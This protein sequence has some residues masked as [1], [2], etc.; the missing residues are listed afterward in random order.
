MRY[1]IYAY[2]LLVPFFSYGQFKN[3]L[4]AETQG[5]YEYNYFK[6]PDVVRQ[7]DV[8]IDKDSLV[9]SS[10]YQDIQLRYNA[11][12]K[13]NKSNFQLS[14]SPFSRIFYE[15]LDDSYWSFNVL[16]KYKYQLHQK[17]QLGAQLSFKRM[18][19]QGLNGAQDVLIS[20]L[21]YTKY[22]GSVGFYFAPIASNKTFLRG[23]Y[24]FKDFDSFGIRDLEYNEKGIELN[25]R[26][27]FKIKK[28]KHYVGASIIL[29]QRLYETFNA[30]SV[31]QN[32]ERDWSYIKANGY[33][34]FPITKSL[35][36]QPGYLYYKRTDELI[37]RSGFTQSGPVLEVR[38]K[39]K[40]F[41]FQSSIKH[42]IRDYKTLEA[43]NTEGPIDEKI[44][45]KY[46][47][48]AFDGAYKVNKKLSITTTVYSRIRTTNYTDIDGRSFRGYRNQFAGAGLR[49]KL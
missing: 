35:K 8:I 31:V 17:I 26:Q 43:R 49:Y 10:I 18:N 29:K 42:L 45:Y 21:G 34:S 27:R 9:S 24:N 13:K 15:N 3:N 39:S 11:S 38:F 33:Y 22:G 40:K 20:P 44:E 14:A 47:D 37:D 36:V 28:L 16:T 41:D 1:L 6:S 4:K 12:Y 19:R 5:G 2:L 23:F 30:S 48:I 32:G 25:T 7:N 46:T